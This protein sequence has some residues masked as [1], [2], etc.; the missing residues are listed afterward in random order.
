MTYLRRR[1]A[2]PAMTDPKPN[3]AARGTRKLSSE[4]AGIA[5]ADALA[6]AGA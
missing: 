2:T 1:D 6:E 3:P 4:S 5:T